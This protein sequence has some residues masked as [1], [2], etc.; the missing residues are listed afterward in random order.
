M[1]I[2]Y[3]VPVAPEALATCNCVPSTSVIDTPLTYDWHWYWP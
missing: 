2:Y 3:A 1:G